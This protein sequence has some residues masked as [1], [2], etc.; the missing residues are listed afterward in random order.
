MNYRQLKKSLLALL[1]LLAVA[2]PAPAAE[3]NFHILMVNDP[4]SYIL[5]YYEAAEAGRRAGTAKAEPV[6]GLAC[7]L[8]LVE[9][10]RTLL[11]S[12]SPAP[13]FLF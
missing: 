11:R 1:L 9:D 7:A 8:R 4:H 3:K 10:E 12:A 5:P 2:L 13:V 6:G